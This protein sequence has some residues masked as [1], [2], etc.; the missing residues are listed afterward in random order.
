[1]FRLLTIFV[2]SLI[3]S[4]LTS[5]NFVDLLDAD[6]TLSIFCYCG[7]V[8]VFLCGSVV[9]FFYI[10]NKMYDENDITIKRWIQLLF[11]CWIFYTCIYCMSQNWKIATTAK[12]LLFTIILFCVYN[13]FKETKQKLNH[14]DVET[15]PV[16]IDFDTF[17]NLI[18]ISPHRFEYP[19][20]H[21]NPL[22]WRNCTYR[23]NS[24]ERFT[25]QFLK[26][27]DFIKFYIWC[28]K[29]SKQ[30]NSYQE[31]KNESVNL[32]K[33]INQAQIDIDML[34]YKANKEIT[35]ANQQMKN[36]ELNLKTKK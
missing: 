27:L 21:E 32:Q 4:S 5:E 13:C 31:K 29:E 25:L 19:N 15:Q 8:I 3:P 18:T 24:G 33:L 22:S 35:D 2:Y 28:Y 14:C 6:L 1:M 9:L 23:L 17:K 12:H 36:I 7:L 26:N 16:K 10:L 11:V 20:Y 34:K 30:K